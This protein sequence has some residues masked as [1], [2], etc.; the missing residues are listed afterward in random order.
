M[1]KNKLNISLKLKRN[2]KRNYCNDNLEFKYFLKLKS[3]YKNN[4]EKR[5]RF[6]SW[7]VCIDIN[8]YEEFIEKYEIKFPIE[9]ELQLTGAEWDEREATKCTR[10]ATANNSLPFKVNNYNELYNYINRN[11]NVPEWC[12]CRLYN[13]EIIL[14]TKENNENILKKE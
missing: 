7:E 11:I 14:Y 4:K 9:I 8:A 3:K 12:N 2:Y 13:I 6:H 10:I 5:I 1:S